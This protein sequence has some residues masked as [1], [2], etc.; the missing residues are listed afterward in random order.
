[1]LGVVEKL[2]Q[3]CVC[4]GGE[5]SEGGVCVCAEMERM[6]LRTREGRKGQTWPYPWEL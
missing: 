5:R 1:M 6:G 3:T 4:P 2:S